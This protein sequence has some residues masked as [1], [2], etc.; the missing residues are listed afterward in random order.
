MV[1]DRTHRFTLQRPGIGGT[2]YVDV[3]TVWGALRGQPAGPSEPLQAGSVIAT[4]TWEIEIAY[5][6]DVRAEWRV[7]ERLTTRT[8]QVGRY[9]DPDDRGRDLLL[10]CT[11][12]Q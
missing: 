6:S 11:E 4:A 7:V 1:G 2:A 5:R 10:T 8:F 3:A 12:A 9:R